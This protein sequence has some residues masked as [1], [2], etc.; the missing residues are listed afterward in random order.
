MLKQCSR[1]VNPT[2]S[3]Q[4]EDVHIPA[5]PDAEGPVLRL[6]VRRG[7]PGGVHNHHSAPQ[8]HLIHQDQSPACR[9]LGCKRGP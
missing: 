4:A 1:A 6:H 2:C 7:A 5:L 8:G 3:H 9:R